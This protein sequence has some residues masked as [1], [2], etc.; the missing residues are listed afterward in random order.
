MEML[1]IVNNLESKGDE[2]DMFDWITKPKMLWTVLDNTLC[3][4]ETVLVVI[5]IIA[6]AMFIAYLKDKFKNKRK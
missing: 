3:G 6:I 5:V 1:Y 4:I 2:I